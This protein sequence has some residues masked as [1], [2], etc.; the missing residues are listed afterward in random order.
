M[1]NNS[2][3]SGNSALGGGAIEN[4][5]TV[6]AITNSTFSGN[7]SDG[8]GAIKSENSTL[9]I[10]D[11]TFSGNY[12]T[13]RLSATRG[14]ILNEFGS[15]L[16]LN[17]S[18]LSGNSGFYAGGIENNDAA[19]TVNNSTISG[20]SSGIDNGYGTLALTNT[21]VAGN[22]FGNIAG[23]FSGANNLTNGNPLLAPL[24]NFGG[25]TQTMP[26][27]AGSPAIDAGDD[28][29]ASLLVT[30]QRGY[31]RLSGAHVDIGAVEAQFAP[32]NN[33]PLLMNSALFHRQR[34]R[35]FQFMFT[36]VPDA[37][38]TVLASTNVALPLSRLV[39]SAT[40]RRIRPASIN[41]PTRARPIT[42]NAFTRWSRREA[43]VQNQS[44]TNEWKMEPATLL[45]RRHEADS[46]LPRNHARVVFSTPRSRRPSPFPSRKISGGS[47]R[48]KTPTATRKSPFTTTPRR[49]K[50]AT[51]TAR[52]CAPSPMNINCPC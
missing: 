45:Y 16:F 15:E 28:S 25:P 26:P 8:G 29:A 14:A 24:G 4:S 9:T 44:A 48:R 23:S 18:T 11:S 46:V 10:S 27:L 2:I 13:T 38:F 5:N 3:L 35:H 43:F 36:N 41:S 6:L 20:N 37:D 22:T 33:P 39:R 12:V 1:I 31:P 30:D 52:T 7:S 50:S 51:K 19:L 34:R 17:N 47:S 32:A 21:I 42:R 40:Q 49:L